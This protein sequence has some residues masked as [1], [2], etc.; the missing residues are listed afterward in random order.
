MVSTPILTH[1]WSIEARGNVGELKVIIYN[2]GSAT[3]NNV[4]V[5]AG[6]DAGEDKLWDGVQ[7]ETF[8]LGVSQQITVT[9]TLEAP[10]LNKHTR[11]IVQIGIDDYLVDESFSEWFDT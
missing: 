1:E 10:P 9:L 4:S 11:L 6:F 2:L 7:S 5:L 3:A 8:N